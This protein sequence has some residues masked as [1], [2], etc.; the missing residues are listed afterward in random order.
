MKV[1]PV[2]IG[3]PAPTNDTLASLI[4][5]DP[6]RPDLAAVLHGRMSCSAPKRGPRR[7]WRT[8]GSRAGDRGWGVSDRRHPQNS[9]RR[10]KVP[11][12]TIS[13]PRASSTSG[14]REQHLP[15]LS[16]GETSPG[17]AGITWLLL[18]KDRAAREVKGAAQGPAGTGLALANAARGN[19]R[20]LGCVPTSM[21]TS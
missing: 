17:A 21:I 11:A 9:K 1:V 19:S 10:L 8:P 6:A 12:S 7:V 3:A 15:S 5:R 2:T 20:A 14:M 4:W 13:A 18:S 16:L